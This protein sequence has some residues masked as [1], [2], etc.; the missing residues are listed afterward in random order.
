[1]GL[2]RIEQFAIGTTEGIDMPYVYAGADFTIPAGSSLS[3]GLSVPGFA[4]QANGFLMFWAF[5]ITTLQSNTGGH[6]LTVAS[7]LNMT[8]EWYWA[9]ATNLTAFYTWKRAEV[10]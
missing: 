1:V 4:G 6:I 9:T 8:D 10:N 5:N 2:L 7:N 3:I